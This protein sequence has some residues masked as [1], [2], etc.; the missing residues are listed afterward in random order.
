MIA[1]TAADIA[2]VGGGRL[3]SGDPVRRF[4]RVSIDSRTLRPGELFFAIRGERFDGHDFV[5]AAVAAGAGGVVVSRGGAAISEALATDAATGGDAERAT[6][7]VIEVGDTTQ[8]LQMMAR[9]VRRQSG[10]RVIAITGSAGKTTTKEMTA[11]FLKLRYETFR[12][13][14]NLNNHI[15]LPL[16]L[17]E[18]RDRPEMAVVELGMSAPGEIRRLVEIAEPDVRVWTNVGAAHLESFPSVDAI[19]DAK[20]EVLEFATRHSCLVM[21]AADPRI[22]ARTRTFPGRTWTFAIETSADVQATNVR[23]Q[24]IDGVQA[25][26]DTPAGSA[27]LT[28]PLPGRA[29]LANVLAG[30]AVALDAGV[31]LTDVVERARTLTPASHRGQV[32]RTPSGVTVLDDSYNA[33][34]LAVGRALEVLGS[35]PHAT[36]RIAVLGEMLELGPESVRLHEDIGRAVVAARVDRLLTVGGAPA[37]AL[38]LAAVAAGL[39]PEAVT[40]VADSAAA[41]DVAA[42]LVHG[43]DLVLVKGSRG[44]RLER[45]VERLS[46]AHS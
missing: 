21:N 3:V 30:I 28:S 19:A 34:P 12:N 43:G 2:R 39:A 13:K 14:G 9:E 5:P 22:V 37:R 27:E 18:L 8:A 29:N 7:V 23:E 45:V 38:G 35:D 26:V 33:N 1:L 4:D 41:A 17:M 32:V 36:R 20:A 46:G 10:A 42:G 40:H 15:G 44:V 16:S 31:P 25:R 11:E 6:L 24:G